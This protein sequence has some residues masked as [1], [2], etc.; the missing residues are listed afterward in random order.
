V[1]IYQNSRAVE[2]FENQDDLADYYKQV[3]SL[4]DDVSDDSSSDESGS[5]DAIVSDGNEEN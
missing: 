1:F 5:E 3:E 4:R 2:R